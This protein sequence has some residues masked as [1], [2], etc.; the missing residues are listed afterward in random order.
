MRLARS[1]AA[2]LVVAGLMIGGPAQG[3]PPT[4]PGHVAPAEVAAAQPGAIL[5]V[6]PQAGGSVEN[7]KAYR[8]LYRSTGLQGEPIAVSGAVFIPDA[9]APHG[10]RDIVAWAHPTTGVV[11][12][13]APTLLPDL[14]GTIAGLEEMLE[15]G[16]VVAATDYAGL[17]SAGMHPYLVGLSEARSVIDSVRAARALP[18]AGAGSRYAVWGH[19]QGGHAALFT[20]ELAAEYAPELH[21]VGVAAA[22]PA[23]DLVALFKADRATPSGKSLTAMALLSWSKIYGQPLDGVLATGAQTAF[24]AVAESCIESIAELLQVQESE[25]P[26]QH[27]FLRIDPTSVDPWRGIMERNS[28]GRQKIAAPV[29]IVQGTGDDLVR[30]QITLDYARR[31]CSLGSNVAVE[32]LE[33]TSHSFAGYYGAPAAVAW[34][35]ERFADRQ[36]PDGCRR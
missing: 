33:G 1:H 6:W 19:S 12:R 23:T 4:A 17:G 34:M 32:L 5:R 18:D 36:A 16:Y 11:R 13:C 10:K 26:L 2:G 31:L 25:R 22:A 21:L 30:P 3:Q 29:Y 28:P 7:A 35:A 27:A 9:P 15:R 20:G 24:A 8:I 14:S